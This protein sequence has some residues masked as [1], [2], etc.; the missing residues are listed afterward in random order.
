MC[1]Y[2]VSYPLREYISSK[3]DDDYG[4]SF[5]KLSYSSTRTQSSSSE[6]MNDF[7]FSLENFFRLFTYNKIRTFILKTRWINIRIIRIIYPKN[8]Q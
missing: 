4:Q 6:V 7:F 5:S 3:K 8:D 1:I 2:L